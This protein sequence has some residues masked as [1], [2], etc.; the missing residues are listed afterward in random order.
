[1]KGIKIQKLQLEPGECLFVEF[2]TDVWNLDKANELHK[3]IR[4][5]LPEDV[6]LISY[7][8]D[9]IKFKVVKPL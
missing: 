2:D 5:E 7:P 1:M 4:E 6:R 3:T 8:K 9:Y